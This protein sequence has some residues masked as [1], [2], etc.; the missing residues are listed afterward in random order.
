MPAL[1]DE[2][3]RWGRRRQ[4]RKEASTPRPGTEPAAGDQDW[5]AASAR[6]APVARGTVD[7]QRGPGL[8][9]VAR[10]APWRRLSGTGSSDVG[11]CPRR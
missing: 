3:R 9:A 1:R 4:R 5:A 8:V 7:V 10:V 11:G 6:V 2:R